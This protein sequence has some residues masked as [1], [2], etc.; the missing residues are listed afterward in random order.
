VR[1]SSLTQRLA[2]G[3]RFQELVAFSVS[4]PPPRPGSPR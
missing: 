3:G 2:L 4:C 1:L